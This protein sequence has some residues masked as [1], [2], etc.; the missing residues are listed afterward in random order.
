M[1]HSSRGMLPVAILVLALTSSE[2][3]GA[4]AQQEVR[5]ASAA[6]GQTSTL[7]SDGSVVLVGGDAQPAAIAVHDP[8]TKTT[9]VVGSLR[10]AR[11]RHTATVLPDGS[12]LI[13]GGVGADGQIVADAERF[14][15]ATG[16]VTTV[17][18]P[19]FTARSGHT[20]TVLS[21]GR[22]LFT[23]GDTPGGGGARAELWDAAT[24]A[25]EAVSVPPSSERVGGSAQLLPDG[26]IRVFGGVEPRSRTA[27]PDEIF[28]PLT[29]SFVASDRV[30]TERLRPGVVGVLPAD[31]ATEVSTATRISLRF[32]EPIDARTAAAELSSHTT[33]APA[34]IPVSLRAAEGGM[35]LFL[36]PAA[37]L[38]ADAEFV[39]TFRGART[40][41]GVTLPAFSST[42]RT[43]KP[44]S[45]TPDDAAVGDAD[46]DA[47][48]VAGRSGL[49]SPWRKL[50]PLKAGAG[51]TALAGQVLLLNGRPLP[52]VTL[53][54]GDR[55]VQTDRTGR[56]LLRLGTQPS[57]WKE[58]V[59]EGATA[60]RGR[61]KYGRFEVAAQIVGKKSV[62]LPYTIWMPA[63]DTKNAVRITSPTVKETVITTPHIPGLELHLPPHT[64]I[65]DHDG[66]P[67]REISITPIPVEQPPFPL[68]TGVKVPVYFTVQPGGA[69]VSAKSYGDGRKGAWLV[70]PNY[71][72][73]PVGTEHQFWHYDPEE[74]GWYVYGMG[75]VGPNPLQVTPNPDVA[76][77]EFT[78]AMINGPQQPGTPGGNGPTD[79]DPVDLSTGQL[80][81]EDTDLFVRD[82]IPLSLTRTYRTGDNASR[83][84]GIGA[85]HPYAMFLWSANQYTEVDLVLPDGRMI[86]Y[87]R[88][89]GGTGFADAEF[90]NT[91]SPTAFY[92][93]TI[94]WNGNGW[95]LRLR[96]GAVY[97]FG[98]TAPLQAIKDRF[99]NTVTLSWSATNGFGSGTGNLLKVTSP[100]G[101]YLA[102]T[103][104]GTN[105][106]TQ[107][108]DNIGRTVGYE[109]DGAGRVWKVTDARG[110]IT[111]Y[112]YD[113]AH[114]LLTIEDPRNIVFLENEY[115]VNGR[116]ER[117][118][119]PD[120]GEHE[121]SYTL[122]GSGQVTQTDVTNPRGYTRRVTFNSDRFMTSDTRALGEAI[123]QTTTFTRLSGSN[124]IETATDEL[125]RV[126]RNTYDA[127]GNVASITRLYGTGNAVT[128]SFT[129]DPTYTL[130]TSVTDPLNHTASIAYDS[131]GRLQ[132]TTDALSHQVVFGTSAIG[133]IVSVTDPLSKT[134]ELTY[135]GG[136]LVRVETPLGNATTYFTDPVGRRVAVVDAKGATTRF[137]YTAHDQVTK[138]IDPLGEETVFTYDGNGN[139]LT[140]T[141]ARGK[142]TTWTYDNMDRVATRTDPLTRDESFTYDLNGNLVTW[143][144]RKG[145]VTT[146]EYDVLDRQTFAGFGTTGTPPTYAS[147]ITTTYDAGD[148]AL[149]IVDSVAGTIERTYDLLDRLT[150]E[151]TPEGTV[152]Y[153]Y[154]VANRRAAMTV[155]GQTA[156]SYTF[157][158]AN[159]LTAVARGTAT[160][161]IGY[162][163]ANKRTSL[164]LPNGIVVEYGYDDDSQIT[165]LTYKLGGSTVG[166]LT[167]AYDVAGRRTAIGGSFARTALPSA[168]TS[169]TYD[170][171]NQIATF[172]GSSFTYDDD[173]SLVND[174][175]TAYTWNT[176]RQLVS[177]TGPVSGSFA[178]DAV[179]RRRATTIGGTTTQFLYDGFNLVQELSSGTPTANLLTG[180][181]IDEHFTRTESSGARTLLADVLGNTVALTD[182]TGTVQTEYTFEP[183][184]ATTS[185]GASNT[186]T[187]QY[188]GRENDGTGLYFYRAR[189]YSPKTQRF[190]SEDPVGI[191]GGLNPFTYAAQVPTM[192]TDPLG[193]KPAPLFGQGPA[194]PGRGPGAPNNPA[195]PAGGPGS[196]GA[197]PS[198]DPPKDPPRE[199]PTF[200]ER[201]RRNFIN[202]NTEL[203]GLL[204]PSGLAFGLGAGDAVRGAAGVWVEQPL[205]IF[206]APATYPSAL[207]RAAVAGGAFL[208]T[209]AAYEA[210]VAAGSAIDA[211]FIDPCGFF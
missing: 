11:R 98:D 83:A 171:A 46:P 112:T 18:S 179:G 173:G 45:S 208:A 165:G 116:V 206:T 69:Y 110:G 202:T 188:T 34:L 144:D 120:G 164:T 66:R 53:E 161:A 61:R 117:Q 156:V 118:T 41:F 44:S 80:T 43:E 2:L 119:T 59:I 184:G 21:D 28:D 138:V 211:A 194:G 93:S 176:R 195:G 23:G 19:T 31:R 47:P 73:Q 106:I 84:F 189:F 185:T 32:S 111:E 166:A 153:T 124:L 38:Q 75:K 96:N 149:E 82:V 190:I 65:T 85:T 81:T 48:P 12:V 210:G 77:Y 26:R 56:F 97:V 122:N 178:Y 10:G 13:A 78:G 33:G 64:T 127:S 40:R 158:A 170:D 192:F 102:F 209:G 90:E 167:Y 36:T 6:D 154:D 5:S 39:V 27:P 30:A 99:G 42:F 86:H 3:P 203:P 100:N 67:V 129:Y 145:Q 159:R 147:A 146:Y 181:I 160:V 155:A 186:N 92:K 183:F 71:N 114:R 107:A 150:E 151:I 62:A 79:G 204:V 49:D 22:V 157:D 134:T 197:G 113:I 163:S 63:L 14:D 182:G 7:L 9:R 76:L 24:N 201:W 55:R 125:G 205:T 207:V 94:V 105:R 115:D 137:E 135:E 17:A 109:Y 175:V 52:D 121:F 126:T 169:A 143:T 74:K 142:T 51:V 177:H 54:I 1:T 141:D 72:S 187:T 95:D 108:K 199:C 91:T 200:A 174:G 132:S 152:T 196:P 148:R 37:P 29:S 140:L 68:P 162:D 136:D 50:P 87:V 20:A 15:P 168:L 123:E 103:Y 58:L 180:L 139:L 4:R 130:R 25:T 35:L 198:T 133:Q 172:G 88:T 70:Y 57:G 131:Q 191:A 16:E 89:S 128:T 60:N 101:R 8:T 104:D 193:L